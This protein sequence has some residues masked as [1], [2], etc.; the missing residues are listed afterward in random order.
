MDCSAEEATFLLR[1][2]H[3]DGSEMSCILLAS[4]TD[5][6]RSPF[7]MYGKCRLDEA[8]DTLVV[9]FSKQTSLRVPLRS[10]L[11]FEFGA[12]ID[13]QSI[14]PELLSYEPWLSIH[15]PGG[16]VL[17]LGERKSAA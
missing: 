9:V 1:K 7:V 15:L 13:V 11:K 17:M 3:Q 8:S 12:R 14:S 5:V 10:I 4:G 6:S 2:W 16:M